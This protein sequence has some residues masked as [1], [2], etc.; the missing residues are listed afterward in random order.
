MQ[1]Y[2]ITVDDNNEELMHYGVLGMKW[3]HRKASA[4]RMYSSNYATN[5]KIYGKLPLTSRYYK[6]LAKHYSKKADKH[7]AKNTENL[8]KNPTIKNGQKYTKV[9]GKDQTKAARREV[10]KSVAGMAIGAAITANAGR[11]SDGMINAGRAAGDKLRTKS[12]LKKAREFAKTNG[13]PGVVGQTHMGG[14][15]YSNKTTTSAYNVY[16]AIK[17]RAKNARYKSI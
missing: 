13:L 10:A 4:A 6:S 1:D 15:V 17:K 14:N 12:T 3:H 11:I 9:T 5:A 7:L 8:K 16:D 2:L